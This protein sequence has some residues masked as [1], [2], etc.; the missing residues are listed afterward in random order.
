MNKKRGIAPSATRSAT[1]QRRTST[2]AFR[3]SRAPSGTL[4]TNRTSR[5]T[6]IRTNAHGRR[7]YLTENRSLLPDPDR[8]DPLF[9]PSANEEPPGEANSDSPLDLEQPFELND[10]PQTFAPS[11]PPKL[12]KAKRKQKNTTSVRVL[13]LIYLN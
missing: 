7:G 3:V 11:V 13:A 2:P 6:T 1:K 8:P 10:D 9:S 12:P 4:T 5:L